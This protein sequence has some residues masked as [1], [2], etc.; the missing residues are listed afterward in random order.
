MNHYCTLFDSHYLSR[1][2][3]M[4]ESLVETG[5]SFTLYVFCFDESSYRI[6][7]QLKLDHLVA[8]SLQQFETEA[9]LNVKGERNV[10]EYCWTCTPFV[11]G[12]VLMHFDVRE[13]TYIDA[14]LLFFHK[15]S[16]LLEE[17][18]ASGSSVLINRHKYMAEYDQSHISGIYCV[19][20]VTFKADQNGMSVLEWWQ[21]R[22]LE[23]CYAR[24]EDGKF[25]DQKYLDHWPEQFEGVHVLQHIG[26]AAPWNVQRYHLTDDMK[27]DGQD[28][29]FYHYHGFKY[30]GPN[31]FNVSTIYRI[32][33]QVITHIYAPYIEALQKQE[34]RL[35]AYANDAV[36]R[37]HYDTVE[38]A[39]RYNRY[40]L[41][42]DQWLKNVHRQRYIQQYLQ[43]RGI[44]KIAI[45]GAGKFG[46]NVYAELQHSNIQVVCFIDN[47]N[48]YGDINGVPKV[49]PAQQELLQ[50]VDAIIITPFYDAIN[51]FMDHFKQKEQEHK[52]LSLEDIV[53]ALS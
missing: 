45:Y 9:L 3:A 8:I 22:C 15:P 5:E 10:A 29:V 28:L 17:F 37:H 20:F 41:M 30:T 18:R 6:I 32:S 11:I 12:H 47:A 43:E 51:I 35:Q 48:A 2:L 14:D 4:Y 34:Q 23:W 27:I 36:I 52:V 25:G 24:V 31:Q 19:E 21:E 26:T 50:N 42:Q 39:A 33:M 1:G 40:Y 46:E 53:F 16:I 7:T 49:S 38:M 44:Q 13:V